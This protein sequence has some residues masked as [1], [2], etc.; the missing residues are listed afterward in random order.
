MRVFSITF[1]VA[2]LFST[3]ALAGVSV[4][5]DQVRM[6]SFDKPVATVFVGNPSL[7]DVTLIDQKHAFVLGRTFGTTNVIAL[8]SKG[9]EIADDEVVISGANAVVTLNR[10]AK[11]ATFACAS[12]R[13]EA[14]R[15]PGDEKDPY[16]QWHEQTEKK[17]ELAVKGSAMH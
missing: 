4:P 7:A 10:G 3:E 8:D 15:V 6:I 2:I 9:G 5:I 13:C 1:G 17:E 16:E 11:Q 12:N 14:S